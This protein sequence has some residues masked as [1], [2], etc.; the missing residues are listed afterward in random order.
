MIRI[1]NIHS[2]L[3]QSNCDS[4]SKAEL[5]ELKCI[6]MTLHLKYMTYMEGKQLQHRENVNRREYHF[7]C[8]SKERTLFQYTSQNSGL[9]DQSQVQ[10]QPKRQQ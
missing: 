5:F 7:D 1:T 2:S 6:Y 8:N 4:S 9:L 10:S 3:H